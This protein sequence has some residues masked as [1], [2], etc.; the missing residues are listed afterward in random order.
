MV[1]LLIVLFIYNT[2]QFQSVQSSDLYGK[3]EVI[4]IVEGSELG[5][6]RTL[7]ELDISPS[8]FYEWYNRYL[9]ESLLA[10]KDIKEIA[11]YSLELDH[12]GSI[13]DSILQHAKKNSCDFIAMGSHKRGKIMRTFLGSVS[14]N[15]VRK[16][17]LPV[18]I[19][20]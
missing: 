2:G 9:F 19:A 10:E 12:E 4:R 6:R 7:K 20:K 17:H 16:S 18:L 13:S 8:T 3:W 1:F 11:D 14:Y 5:V 15:L